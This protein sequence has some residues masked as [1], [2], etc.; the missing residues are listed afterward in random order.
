MFTNRELQ[1]LKLIAHE[2]TVPEIA[3]NLYVS[4]DTVKTHKKSLF[5]K[6]DARNAAGLIRKAFERG[7]LKTG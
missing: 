4:P 3:L 5:R 1:I 7:L 6:L 2:H